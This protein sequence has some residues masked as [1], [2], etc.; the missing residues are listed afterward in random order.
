MPNR[1]N[2]SR[3]IAEVIRSRHYTWLGEG[4]SEES[5]RD[6]LATM[7][8]NILHICRREGIDVEAF[9][10][11]CVTQCDAEEQASH[12]DDRLILEATH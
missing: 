9:L 1:Q 3:H 10:E 6:A 5:L 8:T 2:W 7:T 11:S 12:S 4:L